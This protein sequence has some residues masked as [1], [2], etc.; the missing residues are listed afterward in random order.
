[1]RFWLNVPFSINCVI[2]A[3]FYSGW[4]GFKTFKHLKHIEI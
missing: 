4:L 2:R 3:V 1:M